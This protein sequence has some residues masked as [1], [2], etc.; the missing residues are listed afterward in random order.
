MFLKNRHFFRISFKRG[1]HTIIRIK[2]RWFL[3]LCNT[4]LGAIEG[5]L[6]DLDLWGLVKFTIAQISLR[7][8]LLNE[9]RSHEAERAAICTQFS[10]S[11]DIPIYNTPRAAPSS[12]LLHHSLI[13]FLNTCPQVLLK[14][15]HQIQRFLLL[16]NPRH[17][18][19]PHLK[20]NIISFLPSNLP[21][22]R[23]LVLLPLNLITQLIHGAP[24]RP[25]LHKLHLGA[26]H[27][28]LLI[29]FPHPPLHLLPERAFLKF[30][31]VV[32]GVARSLFFFGIWAGGRCLLI[33]CFGRG[34]C[35]WFWGRVGVGGGGVGGGSG[36][37]GLGPLVWVLSVDVDWDGGRLLAMA[38]STNWFILNTLVLPF[39]APL[40]SILLKLDTLFLGGLLC[41]E[42]WL[43]HFLWKCSLA[44]IGI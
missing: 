17:Q 22:L 40:L 15:I 20:E 5:H 41:F 37:R 43:A 38:C 6:T 8:F 11:L 42:A 3:L 24:E 2:L 36:E 27:D 21:R 34:G 35:I 18:P 44:N 16:L 9:W 12:L 32:Q 4:F 1:T 31:D 7:I 25:L 23:L 14:R 19:L 33:G 30:S 28:L 26:P 39:G 29:Q 13:F 10:Y